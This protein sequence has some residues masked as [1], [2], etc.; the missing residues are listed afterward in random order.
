ML[1]ERPATG[2]RR[3]WWGLRTPGRIAVAVF[4]LPS[5][6]Y[7]RGRGNL[8][9]HSFLRLIHR[10]RRSGRPY[11]TVAMVLAFDAATREAVICSAWGV[12]A[13]WVRNL[14]AGSA[15]RVD[16]G[17]DWFAPQHRFLTDDEAAA[18]ATAFRR[19]HPVRLWFMSLVLGWGD[20]RTDE[21]MRA[22]VATRP[23][24]ALRPI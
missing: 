12:R 19:A 15:V 18:V 20:L 13:D 24:I 23:F 10:G 22:F 5:H 6:L 8:L 7:D 9:G 16:L 21:A 17:R 14:R 2:A 4:R 1:Q 3:R 11:S